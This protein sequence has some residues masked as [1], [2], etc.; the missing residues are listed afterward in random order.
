[1]RHLCRYQ[2]SRARGEEC[3]QCN[4]VDTKG[5]LRLSP[6]K[7]RQKT[8]LAQSVW[9]HEL[10]GFASLDSRAKAWLCPPERHWKHAI[11]ATNLCKIP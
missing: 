4:T 6:E 10:S 3:N 5:D 2:C 1:M 11:F 9:N 7:G 8:M